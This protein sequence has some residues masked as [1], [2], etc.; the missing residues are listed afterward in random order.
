V[1]YNGGYDLAQAAGAIF[2]TAGARLFDKVS[3]RIG[4]TVGRLFF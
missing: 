2:G 4:N 3:G 1:I